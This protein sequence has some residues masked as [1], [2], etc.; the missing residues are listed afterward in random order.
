MK[1]FIRVC[2]SLYGNRTCIYKYINVNQIVEL[3]IEQSE[4][5]I[6]VEATLT[7][8]ERVIILNGNDLGE[9]VGEDER[10]K[11]ARTIDEIIKERK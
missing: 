10:T 8:N 3:H 6:N 2:E 1:Q 4:T 7:N 5:E 9:L 11:I